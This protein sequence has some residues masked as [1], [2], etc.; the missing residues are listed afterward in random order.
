MEKRQLNDRFYDA[1]AAE[2]C[3]LRRK[4]AKPT[5]EGAQKALI[6]IE[7]ADEWEELPVAGVQAA[8]AAYE[9][10]ERYETKVNEL[11]RE[12][13]SVS[14][15]LAI[16]RQREVKPEEF[17]EYNEFAEGCKRGARAELAE[18]VEPVDNS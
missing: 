10:A 6:L 17:A 14:Q 18:A 13:Y 9:A 12:R 3:V 11:I 5:D 8:K 4:G 15:E 16:L 1:I 2:G 7:E